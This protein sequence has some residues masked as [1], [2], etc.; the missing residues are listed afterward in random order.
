LSTPLRA[1]KPSGRRFAIAGFLSLIVPGLGQ[2]LL[3]RRRAGGIFL[4]PFLLVVVAALGAYAGG[5]LTSILA[6]VVTPGVLPAL[7]IF[8]V[9]LAAWRILAAVDA[10]RWSPR[11]EVAGALVGP[12][13]LLLVL[14]PHLW[15][16]STIAATDDFLNSTFSSG[17]DPEETEEPFVTPPPDWTFAPDDEVD[18]TEPPPT[19][20]VS[21]D[22]L[23]TPT[24]PPTPRPPM[25]SGIGTLP[26]LNAS[27]PWQRPGAVPWGNDGK[28]DLLL[29]GSDAGRDRWSRRMDVMLLVE[30]DVSSGKV[31]MI[32]LPRNLVNAPFPPGKA[33]DAV[34]C[35]CLR[36]L[37]NEMYVEATIRHPDRWPGS[38][39]TEGIGA[40]RSV[41][42]E[43]TGRPIDGVLVADL[44][45]VI[46]VVDAMGGID[47]NVPNSVYDA[48]YPDPV[49]GKIEIRIPA[50]K[51][52]LDGRMALAYARS[53]HQD[54]D[55]GRMARQQTLLLAIRGDIGPKTILD[56][57]SLFQ[58]AKG[59]TWTDLPRSSLPNLVALFS[60]AADASVKNLRIVPPTYP[61]WLTSAEITKIHTNIAKLLGVAPPPAP[62][63]SA[64]PS[65]A[66]S[67][68]APSPSLAPSPAPTHT[69]P[70]PT[71]PPP[72]ETAP[73]PSPT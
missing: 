32:G 47:I 72:I 2:L 60:K 9:V 54:S 50:G 36:G 16:G 68:G 71:E 45:G 38:G 67:G 56:A 1:P 69:P 30:I 27:V 39:A 14:A 10:I 6:F 59:F 51:Q 64:A 33:R 62:S 7:A 53:R 44:W 49:Y 21:P 19:P 46:K 55:Y 34:P 8:N 63:P 23:A 65:P 70:P 58:A 48:R 42:S 35:G 18:A 3:G 26:G 37:L 28:F 73:P 25:T 66:P 43:L 57:P 31:A 5:G 20:F 17:V 24:P 41:V 4:V 40:V 52:H 11:P 22:P 13:A 15:V 12:A 61:S 29:L